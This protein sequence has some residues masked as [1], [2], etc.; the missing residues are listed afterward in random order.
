MF[1]STW[2][3]LVQIS[4][5]VGLSLLYPVKMDQDG[6]VEPPKDAHPYMGYTLT[7]LRYFC[8]V[9]MYGGACTIVYAVVDMSP[10]QLPP[11]AKATPLVPGVEVPQPPNPPT[12]TFFLME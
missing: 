8:M 7:F 10:E 3:V 5:V 1:L 2:A 6:N 12:A 4:L 9:S 11:Y